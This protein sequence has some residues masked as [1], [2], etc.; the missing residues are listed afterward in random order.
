LK[1]A[2]NAHMSVLEDNPERVKSFFQD[3]WVK[4]PA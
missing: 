4:Y 2:V 3:T 1:E